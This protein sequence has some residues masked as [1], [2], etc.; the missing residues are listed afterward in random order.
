MPRRRGQT[1]RRGVIAV[2]VTCVLASIAIAGSEAARAQAAS[3]SPAAS[4]A[5]IGDTTVFAHVP[6][7]GQPG[8][9]AVD[10]D[11][12]LVTTVGLLQDNPVPH[13]FVYDRATGALEHS[14][15]I[16][17]MMSPSIMQMLG[18]AV[19]A[20]HRAYVVDMNG[21][22]DRLD[23]DTGEQAVY[24]M[25]PAAVGG[26]GS[27]PFDLVFDK[28]G[29]AYVSD[30][31]LPAIWR[32]PAGGGDPQLWYED[33]R[34]LGYDYGV[35]GIR[36][37]PTGRWLYFTVAQSEYAT[38]PAA[39]LV[40]RLPLVGQPTS[41][42]LQ[43]IFQY[44]A[45]DQAF[46][47]TIGATGKL[48]VT[49][50]GPSQVSILALD[51]KGGYREQQRFPSAA[52]NAERDVSYDTP[53]GMAMDGCGSMFITNS[54]AFSLPDPSRWVVFRAYVGD[55]GAPINRPA[56]GGLTAAEEKTA[57]PR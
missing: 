32:I 14:W 34:L 46:G 36:I 56:I 20:D 35:A 23:P 9:I 38:T 6:D 42:Q 52:D 49:L 3:V 5:K 47:L 18:V 48:Y 51:G 55:R 4:P 21:Q 15:P 7:P 50:D 30:Q 57:C 54:N 40:F 8:G 28:A 2:A 24:S 17:P 29:N 26:A 1:C 44:P 39:G 13:L 31:N 33:P 53:I 10:G 25:F 16:T 37:D 11:R 41:D 22:I 45:H 19:D 12:I 27:M 43:Q